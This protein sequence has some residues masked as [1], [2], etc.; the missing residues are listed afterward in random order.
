[1]S[2]TLR[3]VVAAITAGLAAG[4]TVPAA[5]AAPAAKPATLAKLDVRGQISARGSVVALTQV[6][7]N[8]ATL[9]VGSGGKLPA[10]V[11]IAT[12]VPAWG[13]PRIGT[14]AGRRPVVVYPSCTDRAIVATCDLRVYDIAAGTDAEVPGINLP[15][16]G[17]TEGSMDRG[18][19]AFTRWS[20]PLDPSALAE[21][22]YGSAATTLAYRPFGEPVQVLTTSGGQQLNLNRGRIVQ[23]R[24]TD[25]GFGICG[26]PA[27]EIVRVDGHARKTLGAH[28]CGMS[29]QTIV[30]PTFIDD[31]VVWGLRSFDGSY[32]ERT[33]AAGGAPVQQAKIRGGFAALAPTSRSSAKFVYGPYLSEPGSADEAA[34]SGWE[35][36]HAKRLVF[37]G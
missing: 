14:D 33:S 23:V 12:A 17:E 35:L 27:V 3:P 13:Q 4:F 25:P 9:W 31:T 7:G 15:G 36:R 8:A 2:R 26:R 10:P 18:A 5:S 37:G 30:A 19:I 1:M 16:V 11:N 29:G 22:G 21:G 24:D 6:H 32:L 20:S 34:G 28:G